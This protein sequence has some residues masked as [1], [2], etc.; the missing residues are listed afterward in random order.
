MGH[1]VFILLHL[2]LVLFFPVALILTIP[3]HLIYSA[4][5][6]RRKPAQ[7]APDYPTPRTHVHCPYCKET[8]R[9]DAEICRYCH[10]KLN[11]SD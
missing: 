6:G 2:V 9:K 7:P 8:I 1:V 4:V 11:P 10:G 3:L 5:S